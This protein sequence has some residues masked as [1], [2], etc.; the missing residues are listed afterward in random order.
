MLSIKNFLNCFAYTSSSAR[1]P[2][3]KSTVSPAP[4]EG[5]GAGVRGP[6][7]SSV[8]AKSA[9]GLVRRACRKPFGALHQ[10]VGG[11]PSRLC[12]APG[13]DERLAMRLVR[14]HRRPVGGVLW[15]GKKSSTIGE[16]PVR[17]GKRAAEATPAPAPGILGPPYIWQCWQEIVPVGGSADAARRQ[18]N[19]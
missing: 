8:Q 12:E 13:Q 7:R 15:K 16:A 10:S 6:K 19:H 5:L 1:R 17:R 4:S 18:A 14:L 2:M 3:S 11:A 9:V